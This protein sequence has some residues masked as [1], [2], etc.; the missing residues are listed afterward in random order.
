MIL[1]LREPSGRAGARTLRFH[2]TQSA[3]KPQV[4]RCSLLEEEQEPLSVKLERGSAV[5]AFSV[6]P[7]EVL[8]LKMKATSYI[9]M[10]VSVT[11]STK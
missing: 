8:T 7:F 11:P 4:I 3:R 1:R 9:L 2:H 5:V 6:R 10:P